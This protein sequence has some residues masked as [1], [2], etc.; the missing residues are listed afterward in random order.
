M[1]ID[2]AHDGDAIA[3]AVGGRKVVAILCTHAHDDH[4]DAAPDA[5]RS[6]GAPILLHPADAEL[7]GRP[8]PTGCPTAN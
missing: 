4:I 5:G 7:W 8:T 2:A 6:P 1:L 3:A